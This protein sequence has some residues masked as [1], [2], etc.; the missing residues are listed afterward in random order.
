MLDWGF[1]PPLNAVTV[2]T[3]PAAVVQ[4]VRLL[5][6][7]PAAVAVTST[8]VLPPPPAAA[9]VPV[10]SGSAVAAWETVPFPDPRLIA[11]ARREALVAAS[12]LYNTFPFAD[13]DDLKV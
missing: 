3:L 13:S 7:I 9:Y 12:V 10:A 4:R 8:A 1:T 2:I 5:P 11:A 6:A